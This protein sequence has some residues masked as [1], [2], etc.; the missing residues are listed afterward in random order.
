MT[1]VSV[2]LKPYNNSSRQAVLSLF[3]RWGIRLR[4]IKSFVESHTA[5]LEDR[6]GRL[7]SLD[8]GETR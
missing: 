4:G 7:Y 2:L 1:Y 6:L 5:V 8:P 3:Y